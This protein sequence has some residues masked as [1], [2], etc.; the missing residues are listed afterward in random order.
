MLSIIIM[1]K[2][3]FAQCRKHRQQRNVTLIAIEGFVHWINL[4]FFIL[5]NVWILY[6]HCY[7]ITFLKNWCSIAQWTCW[8]IVS[9]ARFGSLELFVQGCCACLTIMLGTYSFHDCK[10]C[11]ST[12]CGPAKC[13]PATGDA[14]CLVLG[15]IWLVEL[16]QSDLAM[17][18]S[19]CTIVSMLH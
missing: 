3:S 6:D 16:T 11:S 17:S 7:F 13:S 9:H 14:N 19:T 1:L 2:S 15:K 12:V 8:N 18:C 4:I 5:P 10:W